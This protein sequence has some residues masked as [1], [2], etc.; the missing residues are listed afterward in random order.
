MKLNAGSHTRSYVDYEPP[1]YDLFPSGVFIYMNS[2]DNSNKQ[3]P[4]ITMIESLF[5]YKNSEF[6]V[7]NHTSP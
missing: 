5:C 7:N 1:I 2:M 3:K 4:S 6:T